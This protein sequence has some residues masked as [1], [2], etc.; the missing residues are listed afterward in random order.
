MDHMPCDFLPL[1]I[2][3]VKLANRLKWVMISKDEVLP[4]MKVAGRTP[5][6]GH[7]QC[8][9]RVC[10]WNLLMGKWVLMMGCC[11][12]RLPNLGIQAAGMLSW[13]GVDE[14]AA[15]GRCPA[16]GRDL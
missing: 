12:A 3:V 14:A 11:Y 15:I 8:A 9:V 2:A 1:R 5:C 10:D 7:I 16:A 4:I 13:I 6:F